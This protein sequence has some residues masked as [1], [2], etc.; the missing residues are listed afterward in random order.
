L[1]PKSNPSTEIP[2]QKGAIQQGGDPASEKKKKKKKK[3][4]RKKKK[5]NSKGASNS[6]ERGKG[7]GSW[8]ED[9][10]A[11]R[12]SHERVGEESGV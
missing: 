8:E 12:R 11:W 9:G 1:F 3:R 5:R 6:L 7:K 2:L 4:R 10:Q